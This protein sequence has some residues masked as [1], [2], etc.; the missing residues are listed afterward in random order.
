MPSEEFAI[1][2]CVTSRFSQLCLLKSAS[3][4]AGLVG[5]G[6]LLS[7]REEPD[8]NPSRAIFRDLQF[9]TSC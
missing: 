3:F 2:G 9:F 8:R 7:L 5:L 1:P 6:L 4:L